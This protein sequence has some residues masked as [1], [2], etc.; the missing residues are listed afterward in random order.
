MARQ[1]HT[2]E[3]ASK[4]Y[5][6]LPPEV[7]SLIYSPEMLMI[8]RQ[9]A[10]KH[11]LHIDQTGILEDETNSVML[12]FTSATE[13]AA[14]L[15]SSIGVDENKAKTLAQDINNLLFEKIRES[16][17]KLY[18]QSKA[19]VVSIST[20][21]QP[22]NP[23]SP[24]PPPPPPPPKPPTPPAIPPKPAVPPVPPPPPAPKLL[25]PPAPPLSS[26]NTTPSVP[27]KPAAPPV[28]PAKP[29]AMPAADVALT[30][31]T[32]FVPPQKPEPPKP[33]NYKADPY[34][35]PVE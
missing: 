34:R 2:P 19:P 26:A 30:Q 18:E 14:A 22:P 15:S 16:M 13:F 5:N 35:E 23:P 28:T 24:K 32:V 29:A 11:Q 6:S 27:P 7:K 12:G 8:I 21:P 9:V 20:S 4:R 3:E 10:Q 1:I 17:K 25:I 31:K 33:G